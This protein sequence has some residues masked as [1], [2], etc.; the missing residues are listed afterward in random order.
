MDTAFQSD[1]IIEPQHG[2]GNTVAALTTPRYKEQGMA[3]QQPIF[4]DSC[5][6]LNEQSESRLLSIWK[7]MIRRCHS[8]KNCNYYRY[9]ACGVVVCDEW[10]ESFSAFKEWA[11]AHGYQDCLSI[12][13]KEST[14]GYSPDNC[15]FAT[16][17]QQLVNRRI[18]GNSNQPYKGVGPSGK[19]WSARITIDGK[20]IR[21]GCYATAEEAAKAYDKAAREAF[22]EFAQCN[23]PAL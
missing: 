11:Q 21:L 18:M 23:F 22:G 3:E 4:G 1:T 17:N 14:K 16:R 13:R 8:P 19:R 6:Q 2:A 7:D 10:R 12:D 20:R 15:R 5:Q 9:G